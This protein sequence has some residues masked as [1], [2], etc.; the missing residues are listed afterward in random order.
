[1][2]I[3]KAEIKINDIKNETSGKNKR[4]RPTK[5]IEDCEKEAQMKV[6]EAEDFKKLHENKFNDL[7]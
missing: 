5:T 1:L 3:L 6:K 4:G 2:D 7:E